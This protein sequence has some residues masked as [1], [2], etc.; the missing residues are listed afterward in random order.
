M[1]QKRGYLLISYDDDYY[2][3]MTK[4]LPGISECDENQYDFNSFKT[5]KFLFHLFK[6]FQEVNGRNK[7]AVRH[8]KLSDD[9]YALGEIQNRNW[10][11]FIDKIIEYSQGLT[12]GVKHFKKH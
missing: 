6:K 9:N 4:Y 3:Y 10:P 2:D 7:Q 8:T 12:S 11:Y 5:S 1:K